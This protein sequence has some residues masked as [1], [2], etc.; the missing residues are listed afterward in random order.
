MGFKLCSGPDCPVCLKRI[1]ENTP[2]KAEPEQLKL[3]FPVTKGLY[4]HRKSGHRYEVTGQAILEKDLTPVVLY[5][6]EGS[7]G[8]V[9]V[10]PLDEFMDGRFTLLFGYASN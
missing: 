3:P 10:R 9:W 7:G 2:A 8:P 6:R 1:A 5:H 4:L